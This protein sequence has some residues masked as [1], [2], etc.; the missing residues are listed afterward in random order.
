MNKVREVKEH[1]RQAVLA[2]LAQAV[3]KGAVPDVPPPAFSVDAT[4][5]KDH[6]DL[7]ST[8]P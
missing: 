5:H 2:S 4:N 7:P 3:A 1:I 6:G 8:L